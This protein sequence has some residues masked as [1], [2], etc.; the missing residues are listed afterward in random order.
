MLLNDGKNWEPDDDLVLKWKTHFRG[1]VDVDR[2]LVKMELWCDVNPKKRKT[3][4]GIESFCLRWLNSAEAAGN[5]AKTLQKSQEAEFAARHKKR[6]SSIRSR[7]IDEGM[8]DVSFL[9][10]EEK[11]M[12]QQFYLTRYGFFWDGELKY[13]A[14]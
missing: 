2:E 9:W 3:K 10:G 5:G 14:F 6:T 1:K 4:K 12:M 11:I 7:P 13:E 8:A